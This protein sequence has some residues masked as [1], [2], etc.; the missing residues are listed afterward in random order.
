MQRRERAHFGNRNTSICLLQSTQ[1]YVRPF[2]AD[3][4]A[5]DRADAER[6]NDDADE[7]RIVVV[8]RTRC[9]IL[10]GN[11]RGH[12]DT[13]ELLTYAASVTEAVY[14]MVYCAA[15]SKPGRHY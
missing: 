14:G 8:R 4:G 6:Q 3:K 1:R 13:W 12:F 15:K 2:A 11:V 7:Q 10:P 5:D 9:Q